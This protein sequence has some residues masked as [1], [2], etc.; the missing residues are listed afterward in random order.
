MAAPLLQR[1]FLQAVPVRELPLAAD[2]LATPEQQA[3]VLRLTIHHASQRTRAV[4]REYARAFVKRL[5]VLC[6]QAGHEVGEE[7]CG[8]YVELLAAGDA[9]ADLSAS[10]S[11]KT[12]L[13]DGL[14]APP[15]VLCESRQLVSDG[16]T[17]LHAWEAAAALAEWVVAAAR[18]DR[19]LW[20]GRTVLELGAG[21]G[22][23]GLVAARAAP[24]LARVVLTDVHEQVLR[25]LR[26]NA[27]DT[28][29]VDVQPLDWL[30]PGAAD[31]WLPAA[32]PDV[33]LGSDL[34]YDRDIIPALVQVL[35]RLL[36][37]PGRLRTALIASTQRNQATLDQFLAALADAD[38]AV[39]EVEL[40]PPALFYRPPA[41]VVFLHR[42]AVRQ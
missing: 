8:A 1:W 38:I 18:A 35:A 26:A 19:G 37:A 30:D 15:L 24:Q 21:V 11:H 12:Y 5:T 32:D 39:D 23:V 9:A 2:A 13:L 28:D 22:L 3:E 7:L 17:G 16:T 20:A 34:V 40:P 10:F 33:L 4:A 42:L 6:E 27:A 29:R 36:R 14:D 31:G 25:V 41:A